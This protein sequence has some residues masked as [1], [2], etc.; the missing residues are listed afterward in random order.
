MAIEIPSWIQIIG[1]LG[2]LLTASTTLIVGMAVAL[3]AYRQWKTANDKMVLDL[4]DRRLEIYSQ[5]EQI[6]VRYERTREV[7]D[8][9][10]KDAN[11]ALLR[12][13]FLF[14]ADIFGEI[15]QFHKALQSFEAI[16][17][18]VMLYDSETETRA[19]MAEANLRSLESVKSFRRKMP[20][21]FEKYLR[22]HHKL[23]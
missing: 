19:T 7:L 13:K 6:A 17:A 5:L 16:P 20:N 15:N 1:A 11:D 8:Q 2:P 10:R 3:I 12:S 23:T 4:F 14:G 18:H 22:M 21:L 9:D